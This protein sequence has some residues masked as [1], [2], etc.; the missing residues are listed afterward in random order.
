MG[1]LILTHFPLKPG[2]EDYCSLD[3]AVADL[4]HGIHSAFTNSVKT[5]VLDAS[6]EKHGTVAS[7]SLQG[8]YA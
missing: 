5:P 3:P 1:I 4:E 8:S 6:F 7:K 2:C